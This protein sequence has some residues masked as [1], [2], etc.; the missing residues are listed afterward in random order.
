[1]YSSEL[2]Y[3]RA[4]ITMFWDSDHFPLI[5]S[6]INVKSSESRKI[7]TMQSVQRK[8]SH[9]SGRYV[10]QSGAEPDG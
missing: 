5:P 10:V 9:G 7:R 4:H 3:S 8:H 1:M 2:M 6:M